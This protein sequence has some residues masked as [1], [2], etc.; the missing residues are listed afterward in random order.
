MKKHILEYNSLEPVKKNSLRI[1]NLL[2]RFDQRSLH[3]FIFYYFFLDKDLI[4]RKVKC[5]THK[6]RLQVNQYIMHNG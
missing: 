3:K 1:T 2:G 6:Q 5:T 4:W